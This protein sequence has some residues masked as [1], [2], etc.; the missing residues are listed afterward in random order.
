MT[1][2]KRGQV[3]QH[4]HWRNADD[5]S[6]PLLVRIT[7]VERGTVYWRPIDGG[8]PMKFPI[9]QFDRWLQAPGWEALADHLVALTAQRV[10]EIE[11]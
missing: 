5:F 1:T 2:I 11:P 4:R 8:A 6:K 3:F 10:A 7:K 9:E